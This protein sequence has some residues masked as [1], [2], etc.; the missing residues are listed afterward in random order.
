[1]STI[2]AG[3]EP[4]APLVRALLSRLGEDPQRPGL[5]RTPQ[6][7]AASLEY[8]T[9]GYRMDLHK[10]VNGALFQEDVSE[11][12]LVKDIE[13]YS[14]CEHHLLPFYGK[15]HVAY[16]PDG[17][18]IGLSKLP[19]I[20]EMYAR[21][22]QVQERMTVQI[23]QAVDEVLHPAGVGVIAEAAHLC[24]MMRG[25]AKQSSITTTS[26]MLGSFREDSRTRSEFLALVYGETRIR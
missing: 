18:V 13:F 19:R 2:P 3:A 5:L 12:V 6:R 14:L 9:H 11:I 4:T 10:L 25:V 15:V 26:C 7:V 17:R 23:A 22:L 8:L 20:V 1:M 24:M 21:R 16:I